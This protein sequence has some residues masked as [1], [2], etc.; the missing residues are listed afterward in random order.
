MGMEFRGIS[1]IESKELGNWI[2]EVRNSEEP[3]NLPIWG[4]LVT[5]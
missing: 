4:K 5:S 3:D 2:W 1:K